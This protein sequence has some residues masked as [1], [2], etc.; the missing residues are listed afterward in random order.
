MEGLTPRAAERIR[1]TLEHAHVPDGTAVRLMPSKDRAVFQV[2]RPRPQDQV[3]QF[4][5][6]TVLVVDPQMAKM[7]TGS[8]LDFL[9]GEFRL[10]AAHA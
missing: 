8:M 9:N 10:V 5:Q 7:S 6:R 1:T 4:E 3:F 2:D